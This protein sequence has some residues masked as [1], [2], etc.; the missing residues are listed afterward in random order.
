MGDKSVDKPIEALKHREW[1]VRKHAATALGRIGEKRAAAFLEELVD[2]K[3]ERVSKA[4]Q[5][6]VLRFKPT[7]KVW[8]KGWQKSFRQRS[9]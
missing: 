3:D 4:A 9:S 2:D 8:M 5:E 1:R 7:A 6:A